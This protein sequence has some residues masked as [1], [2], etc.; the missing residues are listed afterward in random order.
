MVTTGHRLITGLVAVSAAVVATAATLAPAAQASGSASSSTPVQGGLFGTADPTYDGA[1]RQSLSLL[2]YVAADRTPPAAAV[3][4][5]Q[6]QQCADGGFQAFRAD[7]AKACTKSDPATFSGEDTNSTGLAAAALTAL[8]DDAAASKALAWLEKAQNVDGGFPYFV[9]GDSDANST[10]TVLLATS[11]VGLDP[12]EVT[13]GKVSAADYLAGLQVGCA[14]TATDEDG[15]F[16]YQS[17]AGTDLTA[18][19]AASAQAT[20]ALTG[21]PL[22][23]VTRGMTTAVPRLTCPVPPAAPAG[24]ASP[25]TSPAPKAAPKVAATVTA[26]QAGAGYLARLLDAY[27]GA[28]PQYDFNAGKRLAGT[29]SAGDTAWAV[30]A[31]SA[32]G[33]GRTQRDAA[34]AVLLAQTGTKAGTAKTGTTSTPS[35]EAP[36]LLALSA[37]AVAAADGSPTTV[38]SLV[39]RIGATMRAVPASTPTPTASPTATPTPSSTGNGATLP[40]TGATPLTPGLAGAGAVLVLLGGLAVAATR[41]R[42]THA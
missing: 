12:T 21:A 6:H 15:A 23:F 32:A 29:V 17:Y 27:G 9:G 31:L 10:A 40:D 4:W 41:R 14:G 8:G 42:G 3:A 37:L 22:P 28:V 20:L 2:A 38:R 36:G 26:D 35:S 25:S 13:R 33:V 7:V 5:L 39:A 24:S 34:L 30:L 19:D 18:N 1:F 11:T 16:A